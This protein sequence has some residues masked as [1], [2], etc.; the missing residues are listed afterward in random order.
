MKALIGMTALGKQILSLVFVYIHE[1]QKIPKPSFDGYFK[2][3]KPFL[4]GH[5][6]SI[7][8]T[9]C[10]KI[11][12]VSS[13]SQGKLTVGSEVYPTT[14][15]FVNAREHTFVNEAWLKLFD[16]DSRDQTVGFFS[17][18]KRPKSSVGR[19][20]GD[21]ISIQLKAACAH[22]PEPI[23]EKVENIIHKVF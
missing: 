22:A 6:R 17:N 11:I 16:I 2:T 3:E 5:D 14:W 12:D 20:M 10:V 8:T 13:K 7:L 1:R 15:M 18:G 23:T 21:S 9:Y 4:T 19:R